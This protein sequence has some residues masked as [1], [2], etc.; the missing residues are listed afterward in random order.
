MV[1]T[2][3]SIRVDKPSVG[4]LVFLNEWLSGFIDVYGA[5]FCEACRC[6]CGELFRC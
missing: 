4:S 1:N 5:C 2:M 6:V 3:K